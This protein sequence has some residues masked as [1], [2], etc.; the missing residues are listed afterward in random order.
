[1][2]EQARE[3]PREA[4]EE[5]LLTNEDFLLPVTTNRYEEYTNTHNCGWPETILTANVAFRYEILT[6]GLPSDWERM[7]GIGH[8]NDEGD[9]NHLLDDISRTISKQAEQILGVKECEN[10]FVRSS[11]KDQSTSSI[12]T[13]GGVRRAQKKDENWPNSATSSTAPGILRIKSGLTS[14]DAEAGRCA[15]LQ[16]EESSSDTMC[17]P[18]KGS[19]VITYDP[20]LTD[21]TQA[22]NMAM[23]AIADVMK[24]GGGESRGD[25][26]NDS[27]FIDNIVGMKNIERTDTSI[28][29]GGENA[30]TGSVV[31]VSVGVSGVESPSGHHG[32]MS[33]GAIAGLVVGLLVAAGLLAIVVVRKKKGQTQRTSP[34]PSRL[35]EEETQKGGDEV[36]C[37]SEA[38][39][40]EK[41]W[42]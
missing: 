4:A 27:P 41:I 22:A 33:S 5:G 12:G 19:A 17:T 42:V 37:G 15:S 30:G 32:G 23:V 9:S 26:S 14:Y 2:K 13:S 39:L 25:D 36:E 8:S 28:V 40:G 18:M 20:Q 10:I 3:R 16:L 11:R 21:A 29:D 7:S 38:S 35:E 24:G 34:L 31:A 6:T 1:M